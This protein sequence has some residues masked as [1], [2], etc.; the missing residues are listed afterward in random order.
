MLLITFLKGFPEPPKQT[1]S[2]DSFKA[3]NLGNTFSVMAKDNLDN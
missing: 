2:T 1:M 3:I